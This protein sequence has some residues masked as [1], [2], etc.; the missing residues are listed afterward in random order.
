MF[1]LYYIMLLSSTVDGT[2]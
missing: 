1:V 2:E